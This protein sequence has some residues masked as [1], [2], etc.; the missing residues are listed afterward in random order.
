[1]LKRLWFKSYL[2]TI[3]N[4]VGSNLFR[5]FYIEEDGE[6]RDVFKNGELSSAYY[7]SAILNLFDQQ[8]KPHAT[9]SS[10]TK[11]LLEHGWQEL[12]FSDAS[13]LESGDVLRFE[14]QEFPE[15]PGVLHEHLGFFLAPDLIISNSYKTGTPQSA[16]LNIKDRQVT[17]V[18]RGQDQFQKLP[19]PE[20]KE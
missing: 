19:Q 3:Q 16:K 18:Y 1:M 14:A 6:E 4:S 7:V 12:K 10:A 17:H 20:E 9:V 15:E 8:K 13:N 5:N 2:Q 11:D